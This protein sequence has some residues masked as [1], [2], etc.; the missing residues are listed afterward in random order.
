MPRRARAGRD[1]LRA[2]AD[3]SLEKKIGHCTPE[4]QQ[5]ARSELGSWCDLYGNRARHTLTE[6]DVRSARDGW[7]A[8]GLKP[9]T[10]NN[11]VDRLRQLYRVLDGRDA[12]TPCDGIDPLPVHHTPAERIDPAVIVAVAAELLAREA[13]GILRDA[14]TRARFMVYASIGRRPS[15]VARA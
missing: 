8:K 1:S 10:I 11:R 15:E 7:K 2:A 13:K 9:K 12:W 3:T 5:A 6:D 14:K 4:T